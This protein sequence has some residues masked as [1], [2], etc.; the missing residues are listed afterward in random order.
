MLSSISIPV[1]LST[2][3]RRGICCFHR[4]DFD[5]A[6]LSGSLCRIGSQ[7]VRMLA[8]QSGERDFSVTILRFFCAGR[9][10]AMAGSTRSAEDMR[11]R[12]T[13][14]VLSFLHCTIGGDGF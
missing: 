2:F 12:R 5:D 13:E 4:V 14:P 8:S 1:C 7:V 6:V 10:H 3:K 9:G 11:E